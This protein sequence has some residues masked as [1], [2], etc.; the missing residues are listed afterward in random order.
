M[1]AKILPLLLPF[2]LAGASLKSQPQADTAT[3]SVQRLPFIPRPS[4]AAYLSILPGGGQ[5]YNRRYWKAPIVYGVLGGLFYLTE[6]NRKEYNRYR[7]AYESALQ[8]KP[9]E[10][11]SFNVSPSVLRNARDASRKSM[12]E[13]YIFLSLAYFVQIAEAYVDAHLQDFDV[14]DDLSLRLK[15]VMIYSP[16]GSFAGVGFRIPLNRPST[17]PRLP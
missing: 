12:E 4:T 5:V 16:T 8:G 9:H 6:Y 11:S 3:A 14:T 10:F 13:S 7:T 1:S 2:L 17:Y 15:P